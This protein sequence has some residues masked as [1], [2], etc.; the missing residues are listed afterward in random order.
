MKGIILAAGEGQRLRPLTVNMPKVMIPV[1]NRPILHYVVETMAKSGIRDITMVIGYRSEKIQQYFG[2]GR[3][4]GV[5]IEYVMQDKQLGTAHALYQART[6]EE[7]IL[8]PGDNIISR[9]CLEMLKKAESY[10]IMGIYSKNASKY[11]VID[12]SKG[13][14]LRIIE[15]MPEAGENLVF[16]GMG[17]FGPEIFKEISSALQEGI[18][19]LPHVINRMR[20][21]IK[22]QIAECIWKDAIYPWDL[23]ELN[24][25]ALRDTMRKISGKIERSDIMGRVEIGE[26]TVISGGAY[27]R[28]PVRIGKN[29]YIG[30]NTVILPDT[31]IGN[32]VSIGAQSFI[33]NSIIM[34]STSIGHQSSIENSIVG[35]GCSIGERFFAM[36]SHFKKIVGKEVLEIRDGGI[37]M[38]DDCRIGAEVSIYPG[39]SVEPGTKI[40]P[41]MKIKN[42]FGDVV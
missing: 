37:I 7:F 35:Q 24:S 1:G 3:N 14:V 20:G 33:K 29:C 25:W 17:R 40:V 11:G 36:S 32:D 10:T 27:I 15:K 16:T 8:V 6:E 18:Y 19:E 30:P 12:A 2:N 38:G 31:S 23:L 9:E 28:G 26:G 4:F 5:S 39:T 42:E 13:K 34:S 41:G 22:L 21:R